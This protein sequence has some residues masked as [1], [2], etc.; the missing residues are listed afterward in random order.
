MVGVSHE[1]IRNQ[2]EKY[3]S[4]ESEIEDFYFYFSIQDNPMGYNKIKLAIGA[5]IV[6]LI[7]VSSLV[8]CCR[9]KREIELSLSRRARVLR[10]ASEISNS[11]KCVD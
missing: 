2:C 4:L 8:C 11:G 1:D 7:V 5:I 6:I 3:P 9:R 10:K